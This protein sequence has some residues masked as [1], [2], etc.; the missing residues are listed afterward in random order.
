M[1]L[2]ERDA[3]DIIEK[4]I[5]ELKVERN[6]WNWKNNWRFPL[7]KLESVRKYLLDHLR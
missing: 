7:S 4:K 5:F 6:Q 2:E 1:R 3:L